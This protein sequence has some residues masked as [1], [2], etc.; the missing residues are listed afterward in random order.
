[1]KVAA[2]FLLLAHSPH[3]L[4]IQVG[5]IIRIAA[6]VSEDTVSD[7]SRLCIDPELIFVHSRSIV[8]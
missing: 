2:Q 3:I 6:A 8:V 4:H 5:C 7:L 1:M